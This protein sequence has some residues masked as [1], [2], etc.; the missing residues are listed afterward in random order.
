MNWIRHRGGVGE[1]GGVAELIEAERDGTLLEV[2]VIDALLAADVKIELLSGRLL[3]AKE[4]GG[5][6]QDAPVVRAGQAA[7][8]GDD[9][10]RD[11]VD[12]IARSGPAQQRML[13]IADGSGQF[14]HQFAGFA[15]CRA[16]RRRRV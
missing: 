13:D 9:Q 16:W 15:V 8:A 12:G 14:G 2:E 6:A 10:H 3:L 1:F 7:I 11:A 5:S 4:H